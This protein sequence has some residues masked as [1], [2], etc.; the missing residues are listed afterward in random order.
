MCQ[1]VNIN[2]YLG[3]NMKIKWKKTGS[4]VW[5]W[6]QWRIINTGSWYLVRS[7]ILHAG[8]GKKTRKFHNQFCTLSDAKIYCEEMKA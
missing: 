2:Y 8:S 3:G 5:V 1:G 7:E 6:Q 4:N